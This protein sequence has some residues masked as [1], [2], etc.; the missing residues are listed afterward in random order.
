MNGLTNSMKLGSALF[1]ASALFSGSA[2]AE[3]YSVRMS[4]FPVILESSCEE[5]AASVGKQLVDYARTQLNQQITIADAACVDSEIGDFKRWNL[6]LTYRSDRPMNFVTAG[7]TG[8][9]YPTDYATE[10]ECSDALDL[11]R[12]KFETNTGLKA[13]KTYCRIPIFQRMGWNLEVIG[14]GQPAKQPYSTAANLMGKIIA[15]TRDSFLSMVT[16]KFTQRDMDVAH[17][18]IINRMPAAALSLRYYAKTSVKMSE[19]ELMGATDKNTCL[20][21]VEQ[22]QADFNTAQFEEYGTYC[23]QSHLDNSVYTVNALMPNESNFSIIKTS[24]FFADQDSCA[25][26]KPGV[27]DHY[28]NDL[29]VNVTSAYCSYIKKKRQFQLIMFIKD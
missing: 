24:H 21:T 12:S 23:S 17:V 8:T 19:F 16:T 4:D 10:K 2:I 13:F 5:F 14:F 9:A 29:N 3:S 7:L 15:H 20:E 27:V 18:V 1:A 6:E 11:E 28:R 26:Q 25:A 22:V